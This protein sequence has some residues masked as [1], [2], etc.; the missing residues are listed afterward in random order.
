MK[1]I[2]ISEARKLFDSHE[3]QSLNKYFEDHSKILLCEDNFDFLLLKCV[4][5]FALDLIIIKDSSNPFVY[6]L[7]SIFYKFQINF[8]K[9][10]IKIKELQ[11]DRDALS[12]SLI[13]AASDIYNTVDYALGTIGWL[14]ATTEEFEESDRIARSIH[15]RYSRLTDELDQNELNWKTEIFYIIKKLFSDVLTIELSFYQNKECE[16]V[17][18][19]NLVIS[20]DSMMYE[21]K[22]L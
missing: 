1:D 11:K 21:S 12:R 10:L 16:S 15:E 19:C 22:D 5:D 14:A 20:Y 13:R 3:Y 9:A 4:N 17:V 7:S 2:N 18:E 6:D 8:E